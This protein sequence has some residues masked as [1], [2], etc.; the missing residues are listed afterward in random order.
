MEAAI[1]IVGVDGIG[2]GIDGQGSVGGYSV[3]IAGGIGRDGYLG[4]SGVVARRRQGRIIGV[5][6]VVLLV[7]VRRSRSLVLLVAVLV[8]LQGVV[9]VVVLVVEVGLLAVVVMMMLGDGM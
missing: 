4:R 5:L 2:V 9:V 7:V 3:E 8:V 6:A 1:E